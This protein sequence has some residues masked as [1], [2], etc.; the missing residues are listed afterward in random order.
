MPEPV[1]H[2]VLQLLA[3]DPAIRPGSA[4]W[5]VSCLQDLYFVTLGGGEPIVASAP[6]SIVT[7]ESVP[8]VGRDAEMVRLRSAFESVCRGGGAA[9]VVVGEAGLGKSRLISDFLD[10][11]G[12]SSRATIAYGRCRELQG[13]APYSALRDA[14]GQLARHA[15]DN[16]NASTDLRRAIAAGLAENA[17]LLCGLVPE[18][19][20]FVPR[21]AAEDQ[22]VA[23]LMAAPHVSRAIR[24]L[25][26]L[27]RTVS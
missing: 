10:D 15:I 13:L 19:G 3:T 1:E 11:P 4:A 16:W 23:R 26:G 17:A 18:F 14:L 7:P 9:V 21:P 8:L 2:L 5:L 24:R 20:Q 22:D 25:Q 6:P 27:S 12:V